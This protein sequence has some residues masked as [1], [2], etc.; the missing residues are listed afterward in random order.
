MPTWLK[1][2]SKK[3]LS[4]PFSSSFGLRPTIEHSASAPVTTEGVSEVLSHH[5][6]SMSTSRSSGD[7]GY[8][9]ILETPESLMDED[10]IEKFRTSFA[11]DE[12]EKLLGCKLYRVY[13]RIRRLICVR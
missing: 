4:S 5:Q 13:G 10:T 6:L 11:F 8:F 3:L 12:K 2:P 9:S 1:M 7:F